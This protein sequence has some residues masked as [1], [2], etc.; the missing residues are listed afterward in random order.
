MLATRHA[1]IPNVVEEDASALLSDER[2]VDGLTA[3][4]VTLLKEPERW[5]EM[6]VAG[7]VHVERF[8]DVET[9]VRRL[10]ELYQELAGLPVAGDPLP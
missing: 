4:L 9:E 5:A 6:G 10:E 8:H 3:N 7:R 1:D 2:D